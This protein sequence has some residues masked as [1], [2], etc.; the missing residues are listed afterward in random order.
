M[1]NVAVNDVGDVMVLDGANWRPA[2]IAQNDA[3]ARLYYDGAAW[4]PVPG[5]PAAQ[6]GS[7]VGAWLGRRARDVVE[8]VASFPSAA[9]DAMFPGVAYARGQVGA[10]NLSQAVTAGADAVGLPRPTTDGERMT[11]AVV[12][13]VA[14][15]I[16]T[17]G[18]GAP[19]IVG[20]LSQIVGG[21]AG[22]AASEAVRQAGYGE[23]AQVGA[24]LVGGLGGA[25]AVQATG[26]ALR[27]AGG[28]VAPFTQRGREGMVAETMLRSSSDPQNLA[29][30]VQQGAD[31]TDM[32]LP[33]S[34]VTT[35]LAA[36]D[37]QLLAT[38]S[39]LRAGAAG[40]DVAQPLREAG[41]ARA[42]V[43]ESA[44]GAMQDG[45]TA[46]ERG[47]AVRGERGRPGQAGSGLSGEQQARQQLVSRAYEAIDPEGVSRLPVAP[48]RVVAQEEMAGRWG[49]G[50]GEMPAPLRRL[51]TDIGE[52]GD[53]QPWR[54]MQN[55]R[56][57][58]N[59]ILGDPAASDR[60]RATARRVV[61]R[62]D[63][64]AES[65]ALPVQPAGAART[66][67]DIDR[68]DGAEGLAARP[69]VRAVLDDRRSATADAQ[70]GGIS[71]AQFVRQRG[72]L[73]DSAREVADGARMPGLFNRSGQ[74]IDRAMQ[75]AIDAGYYPGRSIQHDAVT[76]GVTLT[77]AEFLRDIGEDVNGRGRLFPTQ[78]QQAREDVAGRQALRDS[79]DQELNNAGAT[80][81]DD[82]NRIGTAVRPIDENAPAAPMNVDDGT[83]YIPPQQRFTPEQAQRW[84]DAAALRRQLGQDFE[85]DTTGANATGRILADAGY[86][87]PR[88]ADEAVPGAALANLS[89]VRQVLRASGGDPQVRA[90][91][92]GQFMDQLA[93]Q[94]MGNAEMVDAAGI[95]QRATSPAGFRR[96]WD[97]NRGMARELFSPQ[98]YRRLELLAR[99]FAE[100]SIG[101]NT[102]ST[103]N[104]Q[105]AQNLSV[106][107]LITRASNGLI[108]ANNPLAQT[109]FG[110]G[111]VMRAIYSAPEAAT[112]QLLGQAMADPRF[113][114]MLLA[115]ASPTAMRRAT[116]YVEQN[117]TG[118][119]LGAAGTAALRQAVRS[120]AEEQRRQE[121]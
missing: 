35:A 65:A 113:A 116:S 18:I 106:A 92:Q 88:M 29:Q 10:P 1:S 73:A 100:A 28:A 102:G 55:L 118:R 46:G 77:R 8:G 74:G 40:V 86:G 84:R 6:E 108:D 90:G 21:G 43:Q 97:Q 9:V 61:Q 59:D 110:L 53:A 103:R 17:M 45:R 64:T 72:G 5:Q 19:G 107:G 14:G 31:A 112:R 27:G 87:A 25:G 69:D 76:P 3:G 32:R 58:A 117:M 109:T 111:P 121:Q 54:F 41:L 89:S 98:E 48:L 120:G 67:D 94:A 99:D 16:P 66:L 56:G 50:A 91:L 79:V 114:A 96:F 33:G 34:P 71:L 68:Q 51:L 83:F 101:A 95:A 26:A 30:R 20:T 70:A 38:E 42:R 44:I 7:G 11:S 78:R 12:Q 80:L 47:A 24:G 49:A 81:R 105:T 13:G 104:S 52:A 4:Q 39:S 115:R 23:A 82:P 36:R 85:R 119:I 60:A 2:P 22:G 57:Q 15:A 63:A 93:R 62:I 37:P 75:A